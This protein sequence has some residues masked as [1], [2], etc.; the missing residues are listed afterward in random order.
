MQNVYNVRMGTSCG[1]DGTIT[2]VIRS[3]AIVFH[4]KM[5]Y[6]LSEAKGERI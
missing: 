2:K 1:G 6:T 3:R 5:W 4:S